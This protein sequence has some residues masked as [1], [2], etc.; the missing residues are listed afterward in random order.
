MDVREKH[1]SVGSCMC[2]SPRPNLTGNWT[3]DLLLCRVMPNQLSH[4]CEGWQ[5]FECWIATVLGS[6]LIS[7][8]TMPSSLA[9]YNKKLYICK[10]KLQYF[11]SR[12]YLYSTYLDIPTLDVSNYLLDMFTL[13]CN[14]PLK[15]SSTNTFPQTCS[16]WVFPIYGTTM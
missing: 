15:L 16:S 4:S 2:I 5:T 1:Q 11:V 8:N 14:R 3:S 10:N 9:I 6:P 7:M 13:I 12:L